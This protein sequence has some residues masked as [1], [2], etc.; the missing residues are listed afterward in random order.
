MSPTLPDH[1]AA[2]GALVKPLAPNPAHPSR[3][4]SLTSTCCC[5]EPRACPPLPPRMLLAAARKNGKEWGRPSGG[6]SGN[7]WEKCPHHP[8]V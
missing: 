3:V 2:Q 7:Q 6:N 8:S 4:S 5:P 1:Q